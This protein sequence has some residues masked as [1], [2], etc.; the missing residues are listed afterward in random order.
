M[1]I[2]NC[3]RY[4][5]NRTLFNFPQTDISYFS[6]P[7]S[8]VKVSLTSGDNK[9]IKKKKTSTKKGSSFPV[10]NEALSFDVTEED[11]KHCHLVVSVVNC[12]HGH[13]PLLGTCVLGH[14]GHG[15]GSVH[16]DGMVQNQRKSTA[17]WHQLYI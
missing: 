12:H 15:Q 1:L 11:L 14:R 4:H 9:K 16:W 10:W 8:Y 7:D 2:R 5:S 6:L 17:M 13:S 3:F